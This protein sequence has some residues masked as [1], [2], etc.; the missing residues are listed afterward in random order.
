MNQQRQFFILCEGPACNGGHSAKEREDAIRQT[1]PA[2]SEA[3]KSRA[4]DYA[5]GAVSRVLAITP[6]VFA[7]IGKWNTLLF[8]CQVCGYERIYGN[9]L[10]SDEI[11]S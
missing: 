5:R 7:A 10:N 11:A 2:P 1:I 6:H 3:E 4:A 9:R 8:A